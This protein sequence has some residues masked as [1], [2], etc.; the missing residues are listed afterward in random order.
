ML[1]PISNP[2]EG[3]HP[4]PPKW[5]IKLNCHNCLCN[6]AYQWKFHG[7]L[8]SLQTLED[9]LAVSYKLVKTFHATVKN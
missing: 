7:S 1:I 4:V 9:M 6:K 3:K 8:T 5:N 2:N